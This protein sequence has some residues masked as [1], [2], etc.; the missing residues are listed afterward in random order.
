MLTKVID[1][2][3]L[4]IGQ[5]VVTRSGRPMK[6]YTKSHDKHPAKFKYVFVYKW[7]SWRERAFIDLWDRY[8]Q[9]GKYYE[10]DDAE[11]Y[12]GNTVWIHVS[13]HDIIDII[14]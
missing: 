7:W 4:C 3:V 12:K 8:D 1:L 10:L 5:K 14:D 11:A 13:K 6:Y 9:D 2:S